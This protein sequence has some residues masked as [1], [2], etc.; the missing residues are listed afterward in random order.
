M[1]QLCVNAGLK[2]NGSID[3]AIGAA[4]V[5]QLW[6]QSTTTVKILQNLFAAE[7]GVTIPMV[8]CGSNVSVVKKGAV[9]DSTSTS[10]L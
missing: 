4:S 1:L 7:V 5:V 9:P 3:C 10:K 8:A 6:F 2:I